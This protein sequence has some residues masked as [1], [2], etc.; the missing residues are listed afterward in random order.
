VGGGNENF[1]ASSSRVGIKQ[2]SEVCTAL[3][4]AR[5][6]V[7]LLMVLLIAALLFP[8]LF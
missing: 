6:C 2:C 8:F 7:C 3:V 5:V 1:R 4:S